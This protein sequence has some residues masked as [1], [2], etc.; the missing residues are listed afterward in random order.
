MKK[1]VPIT[2]MRQ[3]DKVFSLGEYIYLHDKPFACRFWVN[4]KYRILSKMLKHG[5]L[6]EAIKE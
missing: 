5:L 4:M 3:L 1:G 6:S 2:C